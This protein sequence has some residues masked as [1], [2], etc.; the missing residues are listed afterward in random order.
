MNMKDTGLTHKKRA[1]ATLRM[2]W[3]A[4]PWCGVPPGQ[5]GEARLAFRAFAEALEEIAAVRDGC[6]RTAS[7]VVEALVVLSA[8]R[9]KLLDLIG[10]ETDYFWRVANQAGVFE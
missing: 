3:N 2:V 9:I 8:P 1:W 4:S 5:S 6:S 10:V 7:D